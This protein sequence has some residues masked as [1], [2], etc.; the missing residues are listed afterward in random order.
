MSWVATWSDLVTFGGLPASAYA[1]DARQIVNAYVATPGILELPSNGF[2]LGVPVRFS[3]MPGAT[4]YAGVNPLVWY[5]TAPTSDPD[6]F[7]LLDSN[8]NPLALTDTG[9]GSIFCV[10]NIQ[11]KIA[12][13]LVARTSWVVARAKAYAGPWSAPPG[14]APKLVAQLVAYDLALSLRLP[15]RFPLEALERQYNEAQTFIAENLDAAGA[16]YSDGT[17]PVDATAGAP[18][19]A[20]RAMGRAPAFCPRRSL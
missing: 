19:N 12:Q 3:V 11:P 14:W 2:N 4:L 5:T 17:G 16:P 6:F 18:D 8:G 13:N 20:P 7:S 9:S 15:E 10:E 1:P